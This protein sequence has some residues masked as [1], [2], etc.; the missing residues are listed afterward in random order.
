[1]C[2]FDSPN[3]GGRQHIHIVMS[4][5]IEY[6]SGKLPIWQP[7]FKVQATLIVSYIST[8]VVLKFL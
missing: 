3:K 5:R 4:I 7:C 2:T 6:I 1:M 8:Q